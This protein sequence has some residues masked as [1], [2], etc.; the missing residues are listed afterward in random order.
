M[1]EV[2]CWELVMIQQDLVRRWG[3]ALALTKASL[4]REC[5]DG[6][7]KLKTSFR[8][9]ES[10]LRGV[11]GLPEMMRKATGDLCCLIEA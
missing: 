1:R 9:S 10:C 4:Q 2:A 8:A 5:R 11:L 6:A 7:R 3:G